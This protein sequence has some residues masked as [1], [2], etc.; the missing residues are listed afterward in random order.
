MI[1]KPRYTEEELKENWKQFEIGI[2]LQ[3]NEQLYEEGSITC[4]MFNKAKD[5]ILKT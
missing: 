1:F 3:I 2:K 4:E 5:L